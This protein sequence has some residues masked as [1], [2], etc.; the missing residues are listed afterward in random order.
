MQKTPRLFR[1]YRALIIA[2][3]PLLASD[4]YLSMSNKEFVGAVMKATGG[5]QNPTVVAELFLKLREEA[6][7]PT[8]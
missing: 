3:A 8:E 4:E 2:A 6:G 1:P 5:S 7:I